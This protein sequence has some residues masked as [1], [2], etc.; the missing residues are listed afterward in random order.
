[1]QAYT[2]NR[3]DV[4]QLLE[5]ADQKTAA[6]EH[7]TA[8]EEELSQ[9]LERLQEVENESICKIAD[10]QKQLQQSNQQIETLTVSVYV[11]AIELMSMSVLIE[12]LCIWLLET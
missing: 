12:L 1:M 7:M 11:Y 2:D 9:T 6:V 10:L 4:A 3:L 8:V 5:D